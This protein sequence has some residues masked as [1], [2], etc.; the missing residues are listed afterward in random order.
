MVLMCEY[1]PAKDVDMSVAAMAPL[2]WVVFVTKTVGFGWVDGGSWRIQ[3]TPDLS[4]VA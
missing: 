1:L 3:V 2:I 4:R